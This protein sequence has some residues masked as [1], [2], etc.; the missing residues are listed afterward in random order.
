MT[1]YGKCEVC[2]ERKV[3]CDERRPK[4]GQCMK[5]NRCCRYEN[6]KPKSIDVNKRRDSETSGSVCS[7]RSSTSTREHGIDKLYIS[8][9]PTSRND[10][11]VEANIPFRSAERS[12]EANGGFQSFS[13]F[14]SMNSDEEKDHLFA[15][16]DDVLF[17]QASLFGIIASSP[18]TQET[19]LDA[20]FLQIFGPSMQDWTPASCWTCWIHLVPQRLGRNEALDDATSAFLAAVVARRSMT[21]ANLTTA[22]RAYGKA[23]QSVS[24]ML[25]GSKEW[26]PSI[27]T[28]AAVN[29]LSVFEMFLGLNTSNQWRSHG[30]AVT[31]MLAL[32]GPAANQDDLNRALFHCSLPLEFSDSI[33][34]GRDCVF[35]SPDWLRLP[36]PDAK[37]ETPEFTVLHRV[38][39]D[40]MIRIPKLVRL[41]R[42]LRCDT[43]NINVGMT[44][45]ALAEEL[46]SG[47]VDTIVED[48][49]QQYVRWIPTKDAD[50]QQFFP[51]SMSFP[52]ASVFESI[53]RYC[54][55]RIVLIGVCHILREVFPFSLILD[56][57]A[58]GDNELRLASIM[59]ESAQY[60]EQLVDPLP[61]GPM[62]LIQPLQIAFGAWW[63]TERD[64][65]DSTPEQDHRFSSMKEWCK[66]KSND[67]LRDCGEPEM[68]TRSLELRTA[69]LEGGSMI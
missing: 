66:R 68:S 58:L 67:L 63:R 60:A 34:Q 23:L 2:R 21:E 7:D 55:C 13:S 5:K 59:A 25:T 57:A 38:I 54:Y 48:I 14:T 53:M 8:R 4:C 35:D 50:L 11:V 6:R 31:N 9:L 19:S 52:A 27:E 56:Q 3:K 26:K 20:R 45:T 46:F 43:Y 32:R 62:L 1:R 69:A 18:G 64:T 28:A 37:T 22:H 65:R 44:A 42:E 29:M 49:I 39:T 36:T 12:Q 30:R 41:V 47:G 24:S 16:S 10:S 61:L 51:E 33:L 17:R 15:E 40:Q